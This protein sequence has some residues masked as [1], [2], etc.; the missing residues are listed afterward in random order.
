MILSIKHGF[1]NNLKTVRPSVA[2]GCLYHWTKW[3]F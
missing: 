1:E 2:H 3:E